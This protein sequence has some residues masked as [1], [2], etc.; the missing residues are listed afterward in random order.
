MAEFDVKIPLTLTLRV[1]AETAERA[2]WAARHSFDRRHAYDG[3]QGARVKLHPGLDG[4]KM[5]VM[6][7]TFDARD[8]DVEV[9]ALDA[10]IGQKRTPKPNEVWKTRGG[11]E[12]LVLAEIRDAGG[13]LQLNCVLVG[14]GDAAVT[15]PHRFTTSDSGAVQPG[16]VHPFD[17]VKFDRTF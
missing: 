7:A 16:K 2:G 12:A 17:L 15:T 1:E 9:E 4:L 10:P 5:T 3:L 6:T 14:R 8:A 11:G 13:R